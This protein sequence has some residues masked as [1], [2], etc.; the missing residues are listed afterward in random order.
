MAVLVGEVGD[1]ARELGPREGLFQL[2]CQICR[3][4]GH[5]RTPR[6]PTLSSLLSSRLSCSHYSL[7]PSPTA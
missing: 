3:L 1:G 4:E 5:P 2:G 6:P 7:L